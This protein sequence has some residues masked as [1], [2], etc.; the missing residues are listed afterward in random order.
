[1]PMM[2]IDQWKTAR[3]V[4]HEQIVMLGHV[5]NRRSR[6]RP[7]YA[8]LKVFD[9]DVIAFGAAQTRWEKIRPLADI[10]AD[11]ALFI[12]NAPQNLQARYLNAVKALRDAAADELGTVTGSNT[13][14]GIMRTDVEALSRGAAMTPKT[15]S[16]QV[17]ALVPGTCTMTDGTINGRINSHIAEANRLLN[18]AG[19]Q[20]TRLNPVLVRI[21]AQSSG[22]PT[23]DNGRF[24]ELRESPFVLVRYI[25]AL[26]SGA[27]VSVVYVD[28]FK[29]DDV[30]GFCCRKGGVYSGAT[31]TKPIVVVTLNPPGAG[32]ATYDT[33]LAH[34]LTHGLTGDGTHANDPDSLM[35]GGSIRNGTNDVSLGMLAW[36]R[37]NE[38]V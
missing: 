17:Y 23:L 21:P 7:A 33:T 27:A 5:F 36:L 10:I 8:D 1:M 31:P 11:A 12:A 15:A 38:V 32:A 2:T 18:P 28:R 26:N 37:N 13:P 24:D 14:P 16:L 29:E 3:R 34:E 20:A 35:A 30:Q 9:A 25:E 6:P 19:V 4:D 22:R